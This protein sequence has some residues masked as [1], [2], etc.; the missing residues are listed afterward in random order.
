[1]EVGSRL[2]LF[3]LLLLL[4]AYLT[5]GRVIG[6]TKW[7]AKKGSAW[8]T[9]GGSISDEIA[10]SGV[11]SGGI[12][13]TSESQQE[14]EDTFLQG[15]FKCVESGEEYRVRQVPGDGGCLFHALTVSLMYDKTKSHRLFD[16]DMRKMSERLRKLAVLLLKRENVTLFIENGESTTSS[17]LLRIVSDHY[18]MTPEAYCDQMLLP[19][20][21]GGGP[22]IVSLSNHL[23]RP[24]HVFEL[25][26]LE[27]EEGA[28]L[29][30]CSENAC[31]FFGI[32]ICGQFGSPEFDEEEPLFI[33]CADGRFPHSL[34][35]DVSKPGDH[36]LCLHKL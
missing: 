20:S 21:W 8:K 14:I 7:A 30:M 22:E 27:S 31:K 19:T 36:F 23:Q 13:A 4:F 29:K 17:D 33:L 9:R 15:T 26:P 6:G 2:W 35:I 28:D 16:D 11:E 5:A 12:K 34:D 1:M 25:S 24:V 18:N 3:A 32:K 10:Q